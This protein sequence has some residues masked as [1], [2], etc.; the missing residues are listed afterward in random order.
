MTY[1]ITAN[2]RGAGDQ[3][4]D[5]S[6]ATAGCGHT[7]IYSSTIQTLRP[8]PPQDQAKAHCPLAKREAIDCKRCTNAHNQREDFQ[9]S[10]KYYGSQNSTTGQDINRLII[11]G[12]CGCEE[13]SRNFQLMAPRSIMR[14]KSEKPKDHIV[15][16]GYP[17]CPI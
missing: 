8:A 9:D 3:G 17:S 1:L 16:T 14:N 10:R 15:N 11:K 2:S 5:K 13:T 6:A 4:C 12:C 7:A